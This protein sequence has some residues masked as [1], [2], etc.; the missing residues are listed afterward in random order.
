LGGADE[1]DSEA[2]V[3]REF[4]EFLDYALEEGVELFP[5]ACQRHVG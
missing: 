5:A 3:E 4:M 2:E 1:E